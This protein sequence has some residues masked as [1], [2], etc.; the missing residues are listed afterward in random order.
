MTLAVDFR[1][2]GKKRV[3]EVK[4]NGEMIQSES[5]GVLYLKNQEINLSR[6]AFVISAKISKLAVHRNRVKRALSEA[7]RYQMTN[8]KKG[9]D[10]V[11]LAKTRITSKT[12]DQIMDEV[13][14]FVAT[15]KP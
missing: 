5:F 11:F 9:Y 8:I 12:T 4:K 7:I 15:F 13:N 10:I 3:E 2:R 14:R 6:F 1:I